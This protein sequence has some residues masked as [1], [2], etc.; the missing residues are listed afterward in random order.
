M[1][2]TGDVTIWLAFWAGVISFISPCTLPL[3]PA[4]LSYIT[5][6]G[7]KDLQTHQTKEIRFKVLSHS[8]FFLGGISLVFIGLGLGASYAGQFINDFLRGDSGQLIQRISGV[9]IVV[10]GLYIMGWLNIKAFAKEKRFRFAKKPAG[11]AGTTL[12][13]VGFAAGWTPCIGPIFASILLLAASNPSSGLWYTGFYV[14]G[15][16]LPF[17]TLGFFAGTTKWILKYSS[18]MMKVGGGILII[19][20]ILLYTGELTRLSIYLL[21]LVEGTWFG[22]LG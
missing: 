22:Q 4:Y 14:I 21:R 16:S 12:V 10:M 19:M 15:F 1:M 9:F 5:G 2:E 8:L 20:G 13:G 6:I 7:V 11:Y 3:F 18:V 17:I